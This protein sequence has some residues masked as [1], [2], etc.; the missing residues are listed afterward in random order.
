M[1]RYIT[2]LER[3]A[4]GVRIELEGLG[5]FW[6]IV[7]VNAFMGDMMEMNH[8]C[9]VPGPAAKL[10]C[11]NCLCH[12][13]HVGQESLDDLF[14]KARTSAMHWADIE[15]LLQLPAHMMF[16]VSFFHCFQPIV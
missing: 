15:Q 5:E 8:L 6:L 7:S 4:H 9:N 10:F 12:I 16:V 2:L 13:D 3:L 1:E 11:R 14:M